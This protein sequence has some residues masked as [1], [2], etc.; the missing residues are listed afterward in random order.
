MASSTAVAV[1]VNARF[2]ERVGFYMKKAAVAVMSEDAGT[3]SHA[4]R[5]VYADKIIAGTASV[6]EYSLGVMTNATM[7]AAADPD[8]EGNG[9]SD[10]DLEFTVNSM[11]NAYAGIAT[12]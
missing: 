12:A 7:E 3:V 9:I 4:E 11:F 1:A 8:I 5:V 10:T 2:I 6:R